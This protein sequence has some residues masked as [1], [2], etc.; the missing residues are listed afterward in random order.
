MK[1]IKKISFLILAVPFLFVSCRKEEDK[2][3][4]GNLNGT[5]MVTVKM[6]DDDSNTE[7]NALAG[8]SFYDAVNVDIVQVSLHYSDSVGAAGW[9]DLETIAGIYDLT[10]LS[11]IAVVLVSGSALPAGEAG[12]MR[13][14]L[15][16]N[17]SVMLDSVLFS[18]QTPSAQQTGLKINL[19]FTIRPGYLYEI[20]LAFDANASIVA[21]GNGNFLLKPVIRVDYILEIEPGGE[22][23]PVIGETAFFELH[24]LE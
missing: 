10:D 19:D 14:L 8:R 3:N 11:N 18:L 17:N 20:Y 5:S 24:S 12:Q 23:N 9:T 21:Q 15:G 7:K 2:G 13:L 4:T 22:T 16:E 6:I 1:T